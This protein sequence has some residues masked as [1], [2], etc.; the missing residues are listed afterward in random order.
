M[1]TAP[2]PV[3]CAPELRHALEHPHERSR[4][5][6]GDPSVS[7]LVA[8]TWGATH[9]AAV[10]RVVHPLAR[11]VLPHG[12]ARLRVVLEADRR[13][14]RA[15]WRLD[16]RLTGDVHVAGQDVAALEADV[17]EALDEHAHHERG[18]VDELARHVPPAE[19]VDLATRVA[20]A[21]RRGPTRPHPDA[22]ASGR[23]AAL[24]FRVDAGADHLRDVFD[25][26]PVPTPHD[27][28]EALLPGRWGAYVTATPRRPQDRAPSDVR[29][30]APQ[31]GADGERQ[32]GDD[33]P[34]PGQPLPQQATV[35]QHPGQAERP[36]DVLEREGDPE[37]A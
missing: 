34:V 16:R 8:V 13:L 21:V 35:S 3:P 1:T 14:Q 22:P 27:V 36:E 19:Q 31:P 12:R 10:A 6:L 5:A 2:T 23:V 37:G 17:L 11:T 18:L 25:N 7:S 20:D 4:A 24:A 15:L 30:G 33:D 9:L 32:R 29:R 26:R 28:R